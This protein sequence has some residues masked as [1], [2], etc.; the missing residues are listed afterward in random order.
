MWIKFWGVRGSV[1]SPISTEALEGKLVDLLLASNGLQFSGPDEAREYLHTHPIFKRGTVGGNT[2]CVEIQAEGSRLIIDSGTGISGLGRALMQEEFGKGK[3]RADILMSHTHWDHISGFPFFPPIFVP[4]NQ[5]T[6]YGCHTHLKDRFLNQHHEYNFPVPFEALPAG[7]KFRKLS[8]GKEKKLGPFSVTP[9]KLVHPGDSYAYRIE[10]NKRAFVY[11]SDASYANLPAKLM[12]KYI[13]FFKNADALVF[14]AHFALLDS[15]EKS[16]WGH[17]SS[18]IG[19]DIALKAN[20]KHLILY[21]HDPYSDDT[22]LQN[23]VRSTQEYLDHV[24]PDG[25]CRVLIAYEGLEIDL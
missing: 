20:A 25:N 19:V 12:E 16:D 7:V 10:Q 5:I 18:F 9:V 14:D 11:A 6:L 23:L 1:A 21:H 3:G 13:E 22:Q 4:G 24:S 17:S 2:S 8:A 15:F